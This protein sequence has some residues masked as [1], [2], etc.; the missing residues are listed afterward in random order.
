MTRT[1]LTRLL[2]LFVL[3]LTT[4]LVVLA[5]PTQVKAQTGTWSL[6]WQDN[7]DGPD[8]SGPDTSKWGFDVGG[9]GWGNQE[10]EYY[11][12]GNHNAQVVEDSNA[13]DGKSLQ[14]SAKHE[15]IG[16][17]CWYGPCQYTSTRLLTKNM[18]TWQYGRMEIRAKVPTGPGAWPA[19][20]MLGQDIES[21]GWPTCGEIDIM[22]VTGNNPGKLYGTIHGPG[23]S[24][25][26]GVGQTYDLPAGQAFSSD[27]HT[28]AV[29]WGPAAIRW[30]VDGT[31]YSTKTP[32]DIPA[33]TTWV[34]DHPFF[35]LLN[36]AVGSNPGWPGT[37]DPAAYPQNML[38]DYVRVYADTGLPSL[39]PTPTTVP[40]SPFLGNPV[41]LPG[42]IEFENFDLGGEGVGYHELSAGNQGGFAYRADAPDVDIA[43]FSPSDT[44]V[45]YFAGGEWMK[46]Q[47][48]VPT[49]G[50]YTF[51]I[52][53]AG[54]GGGV[55]HLETDSGQNLGYYTL[56]AT[57]SNAGNSWGIY[58][59]YSNTVSLPAGTYGL[60]VVADSNGNLNNLD[61]I[62]FDSGLVP[63]ETPTATPTMG[64]STPYSGAPVTLPAHIEFEN[65]D[66]GGEGAAYHETT[67]ANLGGSAYRPD[68]PD[69]D[70]AAPSASQTIVNYVA[71]SEW[72]R[73]TITV[74]TAG[75]YTF[76]MSHAGPGNGI[77]HLETDWGENLTGLVI[78][79]NTGGWG[80][81]QTYTQ[82]INLPAG[83][84]G[85]KFV[86]DDHTVDFN[87]M[88]WFELDNGTLPTATPT[89]TPTVTPVNW[90]GD[91]F[92]GTP[93]VIP[94]KVEA[95]NFNTGG[96]GGAYHDT[97]GS[98]NGGAY[99]P[100]EGVDLEG[101]ADAGG[102]YDV[103]WTMQGEWIKYTVNVQT[104]GSYDID[105]RVASGA[106]GGDFHLEVDDANVTGTLTI[107]PT[108]GWQ[109]WTDVTKTGVA[110]TAGQ[111]VLKLVM[112]TYP[113]NFNWFNFTLAGGSTDTPTPTLIPGTGSPLYVLDGADT[114]TSG[115]L[116]MAVGSAANADTI[117][118][119][120]GAN[121]DG[122]PTNAIAYTIS[123]LNGTYDPSTTTKFQ[124]F[125]DSGQNVANA[126]Q[127]RVSYDFNG[128]GTI[129]RVE[130]YHYFATDPVNGWETYTQG[131]GLASSSGT[132]ADLTNGSVKVELWSAIGNADSTIRTSAAAS[133][134]Q[135]SVLVIPFN[136]LSVV[137]PPTATPTNT[138]TDTPTLT[139]SP[140]N[141]PTDT[142]TNTPTATP[143]FTPTLT[144]TS[145]PSLQTLLQQLKAC[146]IDKGTLKSLT[147]K[148]AKGDI[149][150]LINEIK[151]QRGKKIT[152]ACAD[153]LIQTITYLLKNYVQSKIPTKVPT[154]APPQ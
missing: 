110:L 154:F 18:F 146:V 71:K 82:T 116:S 44:I 125:V 58:K 16:V 52:N 121:H 95:E 117:P 73:Y 29:E 84:Y 56:P 35:L 67:P 63:S 72:L 134:G 124:F 54:P 143:S 15:Y 115:P 23:Y 69:V 147:V 86:A 123:G 33:G 109:N 148:A 107:P 131:T 53:H 34:Y 76:R 21:A 32:A 128:D 47:V 39:T 62:R 28:F 122:T 96:E 139:P 133:D 78:E 79:P 105:F 25:A 144:P 142:P 136:G 138:P 140:T 30:Y 120:A 85:I 49:A 145:T 20:W 19:F 104:T 55:F 75:A 24:G 65:F 92:G 1:H 83:T 61:W 99:R 22:E 153:Q 149:Q 112:D 12:T 36:L 97:D 3:C 11:T 51:T 98:N 59:P 14:I 38:V 88:D 57:D 93:A 118:G 100:T 48:S 132:F 152:A 89:L 129:D 135:Q 113:G 94:G 46:Y 80:T 106:A 119:A 50:Q 103:G 4:A 42:K 17:E 130:V 74:P 27:Y 114:T 31:L 64:P 43:Q 77:F 127:A 60:K 151:A 81:Y 87:N 126:V 90:S 150:A 101:T 37:A 68:S 91:P 5:K 8:G 9:W 7:F 2:V 66:R 26:N 108:G 137:V 6:V 40:S 141:T 111:H 41:A 10:L 13:G 102:G 70:I 45:N